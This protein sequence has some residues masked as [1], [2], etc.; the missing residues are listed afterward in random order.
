MNGQICGTRGEKRA[1]EAIRVFLADNTVG[2][3]RHQPARPIAC[4]ATLSKTKE[5]PMLTTCSPHTRHRC[6][7]RAGLLTILL[8]LLISAAGAAPAHAGAA[9][10]P[11]LLHLATLTVFVTEDS[12]EDEAYLVVNGRKVW[13]G[14]M[15]SGG[16]CGGIA[17]CT[18]SSQEVTL[19]HLGPIPF[20]DNG[21]VVLKEE[22]GPFDGDDFLGR[23]FISADESEGELHEVWFTGDGAQ[24]KLTYAL[25]T[26]HASFA[27]DGEP[28]VYLY[29][30]ANYRGRCTKFVQN[31]PNISWYD[32]GNDRASSIRLVG[33]YGAVLHEHANYRGAS[34][35]FAADDPKLRGDE[36]GNDRVTSLTVFR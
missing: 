28:G 17:A 4:Q 35:A 14:T 23:S 12:G 34:S 7:Q 9:Q 18:A 13:Q 29:E 6:I 22:D 3:R 21:E 11:K 27:C 32:V 25:S 15:G 26:A 16:L 1:I 2:V 5:E 20:Y 33:G 36:I 24:Y 31:I 30:H 10:P 8:L 19:S